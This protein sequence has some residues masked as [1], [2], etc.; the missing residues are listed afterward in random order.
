[1]PLNES[2][3]FV[4]STVLSVLTFSTMQLLKPILAASPFMTVVG[5]V[6]G[7]V[8]FLLLLTAVGNLEKSFFGSQ[9]ASKWSEVAACVV[10]AIAA[11]ASVHRVSATTCFLFSGL[12]LHAMFMLS[13]E[14]YGSG[15]N[16]ATTAA[17]LDSKSKK[18][19]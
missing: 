10:A 3:T 16:P 17:A 18:K 14:V 19:R 8:L 15:N 12:V 6:I 13:N 9:I 11:S 5:G 7:S 1:M 2:A 4:V